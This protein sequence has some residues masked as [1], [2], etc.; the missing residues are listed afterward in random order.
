MEI[1]DSVQRMNFCPMVKLWFG[2]NDHF[3]SF[4]LCE[5]IVWKDKEIVA[6]EITARLVS[7]VH[8]YDWRNLSYFS[9]HLFVWGF[10]WFSIELIN[11]TNQQQRAISSRTIIIFKWTAFICY[12]QYINRWLDCWI[13][14]LNST[15]E[16]EKY[17]EKIESHA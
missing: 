16:N 15:T 7:I 9:F 6:D 11:S 12:Q 5:R 14:D 2:I 1:F 13:R 10:Q 3:V 4:S 17:I 8:F